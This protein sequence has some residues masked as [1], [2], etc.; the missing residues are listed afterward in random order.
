[1]CYLRFG[2]CISAGD[3]FHSLKYMEHCIP[4]NPGEK[5]QSMFCPFLLNGWM[6]MLKDSYGS[7]DLNSNPTGSQP[8]S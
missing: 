3:I 8:F 6:D 4:G 1:M 7:C 2:K 5:Q